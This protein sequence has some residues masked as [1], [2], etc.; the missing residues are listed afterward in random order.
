[1]VPHNQGLQ[2][3]GPRYSL[4]NALRRPILLLHSW[5]LLALLAGCDTGSVTL[6]HV[7]LRASPDET[8]FTI[9]ALD[10]TVQQFVGPKAATSTSSS[11]PAQK[12][13]TFAVSG[14]SGA[15]LSPDSSTSYKRHKNG[16]VFAE[17]G[18]RYPLGAGF[19]LAG[20][21][22]AGQGY[23]RYELP[24]GAGILKDPI[25]ITFKTRFATAETGLVWEHALLDQTKIVLGAGAGLR[26]TRTKTAITSPLL[27][28]YNTSYQNDPYVALRA[29]VLMQPNPASKTQVQLDLEALAY[30]G[31]TVTLGGVLGLRY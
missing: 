20:R 14:I 19:Q 1:M 21:M 4:E 18:L 7:A 31:K 22:T 27:R 15:S 11:I 2:G 24:D 30:P 12:T 29:G 17:A 10:A 16:R 13:N 26:L 25:D 5:G 3:F 6:S 28:V 23:S 8:V 9:P